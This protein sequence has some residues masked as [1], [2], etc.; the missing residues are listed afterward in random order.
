[1]SPDSLL[2][3]FL[4]S[5]IAWED[6]SLASLVHA[7]LERSV[8]I[9]LILALAWV[10][11]RLTSRAVEEMRQRWVSA[12]DAL[13]SHSRYGYTSLLVSRKD[14]FHRRSH[15]VARIIREAIRAF[16]FIVTITVIAEQIGFNTTAVLGAV[17]L[18]SL[19]VGIAARSLVKDV[20][21]GFFL[22]LDGHL[23]VGDSVA[24][25][26]N[27]GIVE[28][29]SLRRVKLRAGNGAVYI[30][31]NGFIGNFANRSFQFTCY[32]WNL[33]I[34]YDAD[35]DEAVAIVLEIGKAARQ[36]VLLAEN[37]LD[38]LEVLGVDNLGD[39]AVVIQ[40][41]IRTKPGKEA[42]V[43]RAINRRILDAFREH[44]IPIA[45]PATTWYLAPRSCYTPTPLQ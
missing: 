13:A 8:R 33:G 21:T 31:P 28:E 23:R 43:G 6:I 45:F 11:I 27:S 22:L 10:A 40:V 41:R 15:T 35:V 29:I 26:S 24:I 20:V 19:T 39:Y 32:A 14:E 42:E 2:S 12:R 9:T 5:Q 37:I 36:D 25:G 1:M 38:D 34:S 3:G 7:L 18:T 44:N 4:T 17:A 16:I 30:I